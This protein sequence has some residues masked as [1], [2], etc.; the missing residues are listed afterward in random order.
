MN[1]DSM[2]ISEFAKVMGG[3]LT[4][5]N[6]FQVAQVEQ[7]PAHLALVFVSAIIHLHPDEA[8]GEHELELRLL[9]SSRAV[10]KKIETKARLGNPPGP[11]HVQGVPSR[12]THVF[13]IGNVLIPAEG[14]Y[15]FELYI[16]GTYSHGAAFGVVG[17]D[18][19][20]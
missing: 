5:V 13:G 6:T 2:L 11:R 17:P 3:H 4:V 10:M 1:V 7:F 19:T 8:G 9:D 12:H 20:E 18:W 15:A 14:A 16:D